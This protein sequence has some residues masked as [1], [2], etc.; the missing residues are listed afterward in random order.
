LRIRTGVCI[1]NR[2]RL[3]EQFEAHLSSLGLA[4]A[5][6]VNYLADLRAFLRWCEK[7][8][9]DALCS[10]LVLGTSDIQAYCS[11]LKEIKNHAS[12]TVNRRLQA[13]RK[14]Y[15]WAVAQGWTLTNPAGDV[16]LL[17]EAVSKRTRS[18]TSEDV[19]RLLGAVRQSRHRWAVRDWAVIQS[20]LGAGLKLGELTELRVSDI[21]LDGR[22]PYL[23]LGDASSNPGRTVPLD[24]ET[25]DALRS[26]L[27]V[28]QVAQSVDHL[29]VNR[30]GNPLSTRSVQRLLHYYARVA[31]LEGLTSQALRY[32]Y[33]RRIYESC[34]DLKTVARRL[35]HRH[36]ATTIRYLRPSSDE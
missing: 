32:V 34:G 35:G 24:A 7:T 29:F 15:D 16:S 17:S 14:F 18:L 31:G 21:H 10:P 5:T 8:T 22:H 3:L 19:D 20:L 25:C 33:A 26:Y 30:D 23:I 13:L 28:R 27:E 36:L 6:V 11:Y 4:S 9:K 2:D 1:I 12:T